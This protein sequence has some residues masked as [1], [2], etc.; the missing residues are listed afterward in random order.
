MRTF[1]IK[2]SIKITKTVLIFSLSICYLVSIKILPISTTSQ[3]LIR[4]NI[5]VI[6]NIIPKTI[7]FRIIQ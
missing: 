1:F 2:Y 3:A 5:K 4:L 6:Y 7:K